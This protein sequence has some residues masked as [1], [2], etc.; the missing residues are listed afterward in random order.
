MPATL[1]ELLSTQLDSHVR[2]HL[3]DPELPP[4]RV[5]DSV[6][7][8]AR[9]PSRASH[10]F[11]IIAKLA[12][13]SDTSGS[14]ALTGIGVVKRSGTILLVREPFH[15]EV[16]GSGRQLAVTRVSSGGT[17]K[18][19]RARSN[20]PGPGRGLKGLGSA[21]LGFPQCTSPRFGYIA[22]IDPGQTRSSPTRTILSVFGLG[23]LIPSR[24][25][26]GLCSIM[27]R[28]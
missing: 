13:Y 6:Q 3:G 22:P 28:T 26:R 17:A 24:E 15:V 1:Q 9:K 16:V 11:E 2:L 21:S 12:V 27:Q 7:K 4:I 8:Q 23:E 18:A 25:S 20:T 5:L 14:L 19:L 10:I